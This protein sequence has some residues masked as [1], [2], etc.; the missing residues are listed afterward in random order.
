LESS[1]IADALISAAQQSAYSIS[2]L[3]IPGVRHF[4][5]KS[6]LYIQLTMPTFEDSY[7]SEE[8]QERWGSLMSLI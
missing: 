3:K 6:K 8:E 5:Y 7:Q 1:G 2:E 4:I